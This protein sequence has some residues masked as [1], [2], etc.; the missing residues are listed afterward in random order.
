MN[1]SIL[2]RATTSLVLACLSLVLWS[3][4]VAAQSS[5]TPEEVDKQNFTPGGSLL[6]PSPGDSQVNSL[7]TNPAQQ[8]FVGAAPGQGSPRVPTTI[9]EPGTL[10]ITAPPSSALGKPEAKPITD[11]P[12][13][14]PLSRPT[15]NR[16]ESEGPITGLSLDSAI[17]QLVTTNVELRSRALELPQ[18]DADI[19]TAGLRSNPFLYYDTQLIPY[20]KFNDKKP[21]G[22]TQYDLNVTLPLDLSRKRQARVRVAVQARR[23]LEAQ[24]QDAVRLMINDLY[25]SFV[26]ALAARETVRYAQASAESFDRVVTL[27]EVLF[28]KGDRTLADVNRIKIQRSAAQVGLEDSQVALRKIK[29]D[30]STLLNL[31]IDDPDEFEIRGLLR[32]PSPSVPEYST[33]LDLAYNSR[34]DLQAFRIGIERATQDVGLARAN[35]FSDVYLLYQ[36]YTMQNNSPAGLPSAHSWAIGVTVPLPIFN[37]NQG[38]IARARLNV[39]QVRLEVQTVERRVK[40]EVF[41]ANEELKISLRAVDRL[42]TD[43]VPAA[44]QVRDNTL[45]LFT[46]GE[47]D[48]RQYL[49]SQREY[50]DAVRQY[51]DSLARSR[52][53]ALRLNTAVSSRI[54]P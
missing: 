20:G 6:G 43:I 13:F 24:Y 32:P 45:K 54:M 51:R 34:P 21:G 47:L 12:V 8:R 25:T 39:D 48:V 35:R 19:L 11:L 2:K 3:G 15:L 29:Q 49:D 50:N 16:E 4:T 27:T 23:V 7:D 14:G 9:T 36:P 42:E 46:S 26:D 40:T 53:A 37:R 1:Q 44:A 30:L 17:E 33:L 18:A 10:R 31:N 28:Q 38:N 5:T 22:Q 41:T 52:R